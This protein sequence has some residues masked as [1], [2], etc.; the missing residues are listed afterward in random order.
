M[1]LSQLKL[2]KSDDAAFGNQALMHKTVSTEEE[3]SDSNVTR[4]KHLMCESLCCDLSGEEK[5]VRRTVV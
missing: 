1:Q 3:R 5:N 4:L 2:Q